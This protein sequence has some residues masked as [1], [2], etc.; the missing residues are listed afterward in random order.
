MR[1]E[2]LE[3]RT[4]FSNDPL[5]ELSSKGT[6]T[7]HGTA[8]SDQFNIDF[9]H[10]K[11]E[12]GLRAVVV[13]LDGAQ[14]VTHDSRYKFVAVKRI[15]VDAGAGNDDIFLGG[16][17]KM[18][19]P[20]T[21]LGG[22]GKDHINYSA[23]GPILAAGGTGNDVVGR[24]AIITAIEK[25]NSA[26]LNGVFAVNNTTGVCT[27]LGG[28]GNDVLSG[29]TND[30]LDGGGGTDTAI[31]A[32][33]AQNPLSHPRLDSLADNYYIRTGAVS[34]EVRTGENLLTTGG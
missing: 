7:V 2:R 21:L 12:D 1:L 30:Q 14:L 5:F 26:V 23:L 25:S 31:L 17:S 8:G 19:L 27:I 15:L 9:L 24:T 34:V 4:L 32:A 13:T 20:A 6:L 3:T 10:G 18:K 22:S 11:P 16:G 33:V 28:G 29:D